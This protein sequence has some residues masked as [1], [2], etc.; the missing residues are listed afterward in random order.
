MTLIG[1]QQDTNPIIVDGDVVDELIVTEDHIAVQ[2]II[3]VEVTTAT[4]KCVIKD[5]DDNEIVPMVA[6][7]PGAGQGM[8]TFDFVCKPHPFKGIKITDLDSGR[9]LIYWTNRQ[10]KPD[11]E[12]RI[13]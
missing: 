2:K 10:P 13:G 7:D 11:L 8:Y 3:W 5:M 9:L 6:V 12:G 1:V 4:H